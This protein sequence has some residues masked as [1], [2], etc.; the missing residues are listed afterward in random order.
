MH[1]QRVKKE[2]TYKRILFLYFSKVLI[3]MA[4]FWFFVGSCFHPKSSVYIL[5]SK[6][7]TFIYQ[8]YILSHPKSI[9]FR[10]TKVYT[11]FM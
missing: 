1:Q 4:Y 6:V 8:K 11:F 5:L 10:I 2:K 7:Y 9:Y 3:F